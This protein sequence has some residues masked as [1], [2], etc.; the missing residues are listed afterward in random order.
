MSKLFKLLLNNQKSSQPALKKGEINLAITHGR[1]KWNLHGIKSILTFMTNLQELS[2][3]YI[4][5]IKS[6][7]ITLND[8]LSMQYFLGANVNIGT[9]VFSTCYI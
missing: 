6:E 4:P 3:S 7:I 9:L 5:E 2:Y 8:T 1:W